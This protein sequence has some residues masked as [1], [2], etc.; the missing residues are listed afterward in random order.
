MESANGNLLLVTSEEQLDRLLSEKVEAALSRVLNSR[1]DS[2]RPPPKEWLSNRETMEYLD[3]SRST[4]QRYRDDGTLP[5]SKL[6]QNIYYR[7]SDLLAVLEEHRRVN[8]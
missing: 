1:P 4:L 3:L 5:Y 8:G 7:R 2:A 6:G